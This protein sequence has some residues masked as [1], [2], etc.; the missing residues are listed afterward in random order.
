MK[1]ISTGKTIN[2]TLLY[3]MTGWFGLDLMVMKKLMSF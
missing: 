1:V 3:F 2:F